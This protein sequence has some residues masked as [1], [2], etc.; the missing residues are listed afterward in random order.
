MAAAAT[1]AV[2]AAAMASSA[3][4]KACDQLFI[5]AIHL[6][7]LGVPRKRGVDDF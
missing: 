1:F 7:H 5:A 4:A 6:L 2:V 3:V